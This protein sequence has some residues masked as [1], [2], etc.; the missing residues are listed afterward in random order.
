MPE[1]RGS[2]KEAHVLADVAAKVWESSES[3]DSLSNPGEDRRKVQNDSGRR[4]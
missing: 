4:R 2:L 3:F 1:S